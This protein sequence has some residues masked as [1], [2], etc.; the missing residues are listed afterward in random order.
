M[1]R[2]DYLSKIGKFKDGR[3]KHT[4]STKFLLPMINYNSLE[5]FLGTLVNVHINGSLAN[6]ELILVLENNTNVSRD[7]VRCRINPQYV[8]DTLQDDEIIIRFNIPAKYLNSYA[9]FIEG[10]YSYFDNDYK[11]KLKSIYS[12][13][14]FPTG[15]NVSMYDIIYPRYDKRKALASEYN[16]AVELIEEVI[17]KPDLDYEIYKSIKQLEEANHTIHE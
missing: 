10:K 16:V 15:I 3:I 11:E 6:P 1:K 13:R 14:V 7:I 12:D 9:K 8:E 2:K 5:D 4:F 17:D